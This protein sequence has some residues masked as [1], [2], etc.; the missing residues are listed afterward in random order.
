MKLPNNGETEPQ[1][2]ISCHQ[3]KLSVLRL[4]YI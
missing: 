2:A 1:L 4:G 3:M